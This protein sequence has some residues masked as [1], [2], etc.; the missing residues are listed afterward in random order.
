MLLRGCQGTWEDLGGGS[1]G[2]QGVPGLQGEGSLAA[3]AATQLELSGAPPNAAVLAW[4]SF[5]PTPFAALGGTVHA[6]PFA[7]QFLL[8][9]DAA[10][11]FSLTTDWPDMIPI[12]TEVWVQVIVQD[13][14]VPDG[15]T[16]SNG[17]KATTP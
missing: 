12:G 8:A 14:S 16:L 6:F 7:S 15:L 4:V 17:L 1:P 5:A 13:A 3:G 2:V 11:Q 10:G 9:A